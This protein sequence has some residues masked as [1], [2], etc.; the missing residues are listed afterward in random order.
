MD[1]NL[2]PTIQII[3]KEWEARRRELAEWAMERL[4]NRHDVWGQYTSLSAR[5]KL[6][7]KRSYKALTLPQ[8]KMRG[9]DMVT[10]EKLSR[11]FGSL[12]RNHLIGL[13][14][15][16]TENTSKWLA[17]D[18]DMH[19]IDAVDAE[20]NARRNLIAATAWWEA[21]QLRGYDPLLL[22][23]NGA[24]GLHLMVLFAEPA[25]TE[26][27][28]ALGQEIIADWQARNLDEMPET[29]PKSARPVEGDKLGSWLRLAGLH[30]TQDHLTRVWSGDTWLDDPWQDG[31][32]AIET[33]LNTIPGAT[34]PPPPEDDGAP[35]AKKKKKKSAKKSASSRRSRPESKKGKICIDLDGV[36]AHYQG[37]QGNEIIGEPIDGAV[38]FTRKVAE[39]ATVTIHTAR[40]SG[41]EENDGKVEKLLR[42]WLDEN[43]LAY[44]EIHTG[45]GKPRAD[46]YI[47][48]RAIN[49][50]PQEQG[51]N[52][53]ASAELRARQLAEKKQ[54]ADAD[55]LFAE[56]VD[57][58]ARLTPDQRES[59][60]EG[61]RNS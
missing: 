26:N 56:L 39:F 51:I 53:F 20:D 4:V 55:P 1:P 3:G 5:E 7:S 2:P 36:L 28:Y 61:F 49:C 54:G 21:L 46:A 6:T 16:S 17:I 25:P 40:F 22:D 33:M 12:R 31:D 14:A 37:W 27:V 32:A 41:D 23:S 52:A 43:Q 24:G 30:H 29:F 42:A 35:P 13:H 34:P 10:L 38:E 44:D 11:H 58:W 8:K 19:E 45:A 59:L 15:A 9:S 60:L 50:Q 57:H 48:D 18:I 47:D